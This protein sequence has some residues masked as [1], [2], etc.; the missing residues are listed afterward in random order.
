MYIFE[1][2]YIYIYYQKLV[3][4]EPCF[5]RNAAIFDQLYCYIEPGRPASRL[6]ATQPHLAKAWRGLGSW[7]YHGLPW[8]FVC[9]LR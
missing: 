1:Y 4:I 7:V 8:G 5:T 9:C 3:R 2:V 6:R